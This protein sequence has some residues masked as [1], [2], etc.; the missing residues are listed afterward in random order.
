MA[1]MQN[2]MKCLAEQQGLQLGNGDNISAPLQA[3]APQMPWDCGPVT[4]LR[5]EK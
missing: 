4:V 2:Q 1:Q 3:R 5:D